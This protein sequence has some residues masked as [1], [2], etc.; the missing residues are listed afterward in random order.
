MN[1]R[2]GVMFDALPGLWRE[3]FKQPV[4][5]RRWP[6]SR[7][8]EVRRSTSPRDAQTRRPRRR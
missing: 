8:P 2:N 3:M 7:D 5:E 6:R 1:L 4:A